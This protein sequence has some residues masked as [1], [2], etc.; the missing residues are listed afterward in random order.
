M[1]RM[2]PGLKEAELLNREEEG[3]WEQGPLGRQG[4]R[5]LPI[6]LHHAAAQQTCNERQPS[7]M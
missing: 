5:R 3:G 7:D 2:R 1:G 4:A 6:Q